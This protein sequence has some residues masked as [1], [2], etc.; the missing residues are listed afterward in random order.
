MRR[1]LGSQVERS[2]RSIKEVVVDF[3]VQQLPPNEQRGNYA[4]GVDAT[5]AEAKKTEMGKYATGKNVPK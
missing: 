2:D 3:T 4:S 5:V 1:K